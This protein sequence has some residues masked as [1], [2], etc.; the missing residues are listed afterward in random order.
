M[1]ITIEVQDLVKDFPI[2]GGLHRTRLRAVDH[3]SFTIPPCRTLGLVGE[4]G[5]GKST[6]ARMIARLEKPT[7]G[8][9]TLCGP[10]GTRV[11]DAANRDHVQMVFQDPFASLNPFTRSS[12]TWPGRCDCTAGRATGRRPGGRCW[13]YWSGL[14]CPCGRSCTAGR[15]SCP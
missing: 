3:V 10:G 4:S 11:P 2:R 8:R 1:S 6:L 7:A 9:I 12:T 15:T 5:S 14:P 13:S